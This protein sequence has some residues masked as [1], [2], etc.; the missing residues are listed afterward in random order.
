M[1]DPT[2]VIR[3]RGSTAG[4]DDITIYNS[5]GK[6]RAVVTSRAES[7]VVRMG[8]T[9]GEDLVVVYRNGRVDV[10]VRW[11]RARVW[12]ASARGFNGAKFT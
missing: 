4:I 12:S 2:K 8:W 10:Y 11:G 3:V 1:R 6:R 9:V 5:V 7:T